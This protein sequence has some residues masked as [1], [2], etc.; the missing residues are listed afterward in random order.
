MYLCSVS[1]FHGC[2]CLFVSRERKCASVYITVT[3]LFVKGFREL[4]RHIGGVSGCHAITNE[5]NDKL[6]ALHHVECHIGVRNELSCFH[7]ANTCLLGRAC[8][9]VGCGDG[10]F[11]ST[12]PLL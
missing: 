5:P 9:A 6:I 8:D 12:F 4:W 7:F 11:L 10:E 2:S 3:K 1:Y